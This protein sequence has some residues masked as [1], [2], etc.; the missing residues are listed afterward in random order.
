MHTTSGGPR[1][2]AKEWCLKDSF[3]RSSP[4]NDEGMCPHTM[5]SLAQKSVRWGRRWWSTA[6]VT[7]FSYPA[8]CV[9][10]IQLGQ[11]ESF[12]PQKPTGVAQTETIRSTTVGDFSTY[13]FTLNQVNQNR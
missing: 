13:Y 1:P 10:F 12:P 7:S 3:G 5:R 2:Q 4:G 9:E 11:L 8:G 6:P